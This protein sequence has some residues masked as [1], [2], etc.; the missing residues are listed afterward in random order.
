M[1]DLDLATLDRDGA[2]RE[3]ADKIADTRAGF[4]GKAALAAG[5][6]MGGGAVLGAT[7]VRAASLSDTD[8]DI[9]NFALTLE[10]LEATFYE[11]SLKH[12]GLHGRVLHFARVVNAHEHTHVRALKKVLGGKAIKKPAFDFGSAVQSRAA[13]VKT[14]IQLEDTGVRAY[15]G[16]A[17]RIKSKAILASALSIHTVEAKHAAWIRYLA[18]QSPSPVSEEQPLTMQAVRSRVAATGF[19]KGS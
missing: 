9:L 5:G 4:L 10:Y 8:V 12:A 2:V 1:H 17:P 18:N 16:Q 13:F 6:L 7:S 11:R 3:A 19:I 15:K 14:S